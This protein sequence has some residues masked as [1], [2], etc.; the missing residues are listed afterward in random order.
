MGKITYCAWINILEKVEAHLHKINEQDTWLKK[1]APSMASFFDLFGFDWFGL[2]T[3][4]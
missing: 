4:L 1:V 2:R 3:G